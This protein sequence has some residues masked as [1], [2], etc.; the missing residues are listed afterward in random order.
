M[1][2]R[3]KHVVFLDPSEW[4][5]IC[6]EADRDSRHSSEWMRLTL[7]SELRRRGRVGANGEALLSIPIDD[8]ERKVAA[9]VLQPACAAPTTAPPLS[10]NFR[11]GAFASA[12]EPQAPESLSAEDIRA[13]IRSASSPAVPKPWTPPACLEE[14]LRRTPCAPGVCV[15]ETCGSWPHGR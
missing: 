2:K 12:A 9:P 14:A 8:V 6:A 5:L 11:P 10:V 13:Q 7:L 15:A 4:A 3:E 1:A